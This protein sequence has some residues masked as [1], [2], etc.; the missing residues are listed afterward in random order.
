MTTILKG[1]TSAEM[2]VTI[3]EGLAA[4][5][6]V[7]RMR[8]QGARR[9]FAIAGTGAKT[10]R[11]SFTADETAHMAL[12][13]WPVEISVQRPDG[14]VLTV[15]NSQTRICVTDCP[16]D[17]RGGGA[18]AVDAK[19]ALYG[20]EGLP[21][22]YTSKDLW[23]KVNEVIRLLGGSV[24]A[25]AVAC[26]ATAAALAAE[27]STAPMGE[28][29]NDMPV[30]TNVTFEGLATTAEV[31]AST[32]ALSASVGRQI[33]DMAMGAG[34]TNAVRSVAHTLADYAWDAESEV[35]WRRVVSGG[36][37]D[38]VAVTNIDLTLPENAAALEAAEAA[39][40]AK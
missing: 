27:V 7:V 20:V 31:N 29:Y 18:F 28:V 16:S 6:A 4:D 34:M 40:R 35:C 24:A 25:V 33:A 22:R 30:V 14:S 1:D 32:N 8:Y 17:V 39:R 38:Y 5:G 15:E 12:G 10:L 23:N 26:V 11:L 3:A 2:S 19:G 21:E 9:T 36:Y 37:I 13:A